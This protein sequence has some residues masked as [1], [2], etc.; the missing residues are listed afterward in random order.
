MGS[1]YMVDHTSWRRGVMLGKMN[2][3]DPNASFK[4]NVW[5]TFVPERSPTFRTHTN[6][7]HALNAVS[8]ADYAILYKLGSQGWVKV[9]QKEG[10][11]GKFARVDGTDK[12][13]DPPTIVV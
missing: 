1:S 8:H 11:G 7:G 3:F 12:V 10:R 4:G 9:T 13:A 2:E 6:R 5:A